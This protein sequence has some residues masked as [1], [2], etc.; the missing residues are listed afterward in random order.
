[1][2]KIMDSTVQLEV[3]KCAMRNIDI[4]RDVDMSQWV[5]WIKIFFMDLSC[6][7]L[8]VELLRLILA[9]CL[10]KE[11]SWLDERDFDRYRCQ[12]SFSC[13]STIF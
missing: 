12:A 5:T 10:A 3:S 11:S 13:K 9:M 8:V 1:M 2:W 4:V 7:S 6:V